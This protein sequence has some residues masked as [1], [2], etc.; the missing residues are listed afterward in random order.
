MRIYKAT[1]SGQFLPLTQIDEPCTVMS[2][3][4]QVDFM[5]FTKTVQLPQ[6]AFAVG[7]SIQDVCDAVRIGTTQFV[8]IDITGVRRLG[9]WVHSK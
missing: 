2:S 3:L 1:D 5:A 6:T 7:E 8:S 4:W 9:S